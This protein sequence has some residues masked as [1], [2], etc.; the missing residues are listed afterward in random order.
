M[1]AVCVT[2][3]TSG[4][5]WPMAFYSFSIS[6]RSGRGKAYNERLSAMKRRRRLG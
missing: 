1:T 3:Q 6:V 4:D 2:F 5:S